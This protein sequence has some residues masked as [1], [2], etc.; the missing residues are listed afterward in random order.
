MGKY[1]IISVSCRQAKT[2]KIKNNILFYTNYSRGVCG[3]WGL[4]NLKVFNSPAL[5]WS[6]EK[7][8]ECSSKLLPLSPLQ[9]QSHKGNHSQTVREIPPPRNGS[10]AYFSEVL[11]KWSAAVTKD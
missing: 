8:S 1:S 10:W 7:T 6:T 3:I 11:W 2:D 9:Q 5:T 4:I